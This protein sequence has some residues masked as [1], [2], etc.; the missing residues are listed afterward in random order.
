MPPCVQIHFLILST[1]QPFISANEAFQP[2]KLIHHKTSLIS[3]CTLEK[4][5]LTHFIIKLLPGVPQTSVQNPDSSRAGIF[6]KL[7]QN[8][9]LRLS[10]INW[11][12]GK[13]PGE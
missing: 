12:T 10:L 13:L 4:L 5:L 3:P 9:Q 1:L 11:E 7:L 2:C 6:L 8:L